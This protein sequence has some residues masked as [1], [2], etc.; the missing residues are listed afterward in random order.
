VYHVGGATLN[1]G[2]PRKTYLNFRNSLLMVIKNIPSAKLP[3]VFFLRLLLDGLAGINYLFHGKFAHTWAIVKAHF[4]V[5][6]LF[7]KFLNKRKSKK[8]KNYYKVN[9]IVALYYLKN[10]RTFGEKFNN[11]L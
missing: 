7:Y 4:K 5:Y 6:T 11:S 2:N 8:Y 9:S 1:T 3:I 10:I